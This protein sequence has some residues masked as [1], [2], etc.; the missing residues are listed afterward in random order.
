M[1]SGTL[2]ANN[3]IVVNDTKIYGNLTVN[4][5]I[6]TN[7]IYPTNLYGGYW[8]LKTF[9]NYE[10]VTTTNSVSNALPLTRLSS[11]LSVRTGRT[12]NNISYGYS[13][14]YYSENTIVIKTQ[15]TDAEVRYWLITELGY[16]N[17]GT[18]SINYPIVASN[19]FFGNINYSNIFTTYSDSAYSTLTSGTEFPATTNAWNNITPANTGI[20]INN[21]PISFTV[22]A[23]SYVKMWLVIDMGN[24]SYGNNTV[25]STLRISNPVITPTFTI[26]K[27]NVFGILNS[28]DG[29][30]TSTITSSGAAVD[31]STKNITGVGAITAAGQVN[32]GAI[33]A[34]GQVNVGSITTSGAAVDFNSKNLTGI[35]A[36]T[37]SGQIQATSFNAQSDRRLK[38][39]IHSLSSSL[40]KINQLNPV[41]YEWK[42]SGRPDYGFVAQDYY[43]IF[44]DLCPAGLEGE[45]PVDTEGKPV[46]YTIDYGKITCFLTGAVQELA[47]KN[48]SFHGEGTIAPNQFATTISLPPEH[49]PEQ[50]YIVQITPILTKNSL[51]TSRIENGQFTVYGNAGSFYWSVIPSS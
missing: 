20:F 40:E 31:F 22:A 35:G 46:H 17:A 9:G 41:Q 32:V 18:Y 26:S 23:N 14:S 30:T 50:I 45:E 10:L 39:N 16:V 21:A 6:F 36:I 48:K 37:A 8:Y 33:T 28:V 25:G 47:K 12:V 3:L 2:G 38:G 15:R 11:T 7:N 13:I 19:N 27:I 24:S 1:Q 29:I 49:N 42:S 43:K 4:N 5:N 51:F 34:S 44:P